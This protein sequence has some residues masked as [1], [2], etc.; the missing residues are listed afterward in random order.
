MADSITIQKTEG[1]K[2]ESFDSRIESLKYTM[3]VLD[4]AV[5]QL[6][7]MMLI[8]APPK[9]RAAALA[10]LASLGYDRD[11]MSEEVQEELD[12]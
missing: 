6:T 2:P 8:G 5:V 12:G 1:V 4:T 7:E 9:R 3:S 11:E 10:I